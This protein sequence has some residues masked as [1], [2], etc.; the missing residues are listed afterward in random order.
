[1]WGNLLNFW[2]GRDFLTKVYE[3]FSD[4]L[5][6]SKDMFDMVCKKLMQGM[7]DLELKDRIYAL[8]KGVNKL[9]RDIRKHIIEHL[10]VQP[11]QDVPFCLILM[12]VVKDAER[13]GDYAKNL[14]QVTEILHKPIDNKIYDHYFD[15]LDEKI[16]DLFDKTKTAFI[17]S[18]EKLATELTSLERHIVKKCD[19]II[20]NLSKSSLT[21]NEAVCLT[22][23]ARYFK[24]TAAHLTNIGT[25][26]VLPISKLDFF[27]EKLRHADVK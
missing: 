10:S 3:E 17:E 4:M 11:A 1:M 2:K 8:D 26:V 25:S 9:E 12:S 20:I 6:N 16:S 14:F 27:D 19:Q 15:K 5:T 13:L 7:V 22:L 21:T 23:I 24:R 18:D